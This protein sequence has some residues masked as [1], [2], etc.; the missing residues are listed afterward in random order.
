MSMVKLDSNFKSCT[1][2]SDLLKISSQ[3]VL[4]VPF[5]SSSPRIASDWPGRVILEVQHRIHR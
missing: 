4:D 5:G 1:A 3:K 2:T